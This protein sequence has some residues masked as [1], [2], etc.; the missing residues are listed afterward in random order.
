MTPNLARLV[1]RHALRFIP[2]GNRELL[3]AAPAFLESRGDA[4]KIMSS[5]PANDRCHG[6]T[7]R[8]WRAERKRLITHLSTKLCARS[9]RGPQRIDQPDSS[10]DASAAAPSY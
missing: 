5:K 8:V 1:V 9:P 2:Y 7:F 6:D 3:T 4:H 10:F